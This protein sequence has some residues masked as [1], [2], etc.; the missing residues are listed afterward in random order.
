MKE[1]NQL[2]DFIAASP[3]PWHAVSAV[4]ALLKA[5]GYKPLQEND[6]W[7][8]V[9]GDRYY[10]VR[11]GS[12]LIA[13][14]MPKIPGAGWRMAAAHSDSPAF[15]VKGARLQNGCTLLDTEGYG[16]MIRASW[17]DR[18]LGLAG[19][20]LVRTETGVERRLIGPDRDL[21]VIPH[22]AIHFDRAMNEGHKYDLKKD[23]QALFA[24]GDKTERYRELLAAEASCR[25]EN[26]L[27]EELLLYC[28]Q[29]GAVAGAAGELI[30]CPRLDDLGC[31]WAT[32]KGFLA[33]EGKNP[34]QGAV[35]CLFDNEEVGSGTRQGACGSFLPD[36]LARAGA[37]LGENEETRRVALARSLLLSADNGHATHPNFAE[38]SDG[39]HPV[40]LNEGVVL[41]FNASQK[42][43]TSA[44]TAALFR[45]V[46]AA[47]GVPVQDYYNRADLPGGSTLG[48]LL[49][50]QVSVPMADVGL[51]QLAMHSCVETAGARDVEYLLTA[52]AA[53]YG[54]AIEPAEQGYRV[55]L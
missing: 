2:F 36:I 55:E 26:I 10:T 12:S 1:L 13:W 24:P 11:A 42:Y 43:T 35:W 37:A 52:C 39:G 30:L 28:R 8:L 6:C 48:N 27:S 4:G 21:A 34:T 40:R 47:A 31:A 19:R 38:M 15:K 16:G 54:A 18:P 23:M 7:S 20:V 22:L 14:R 5:A 3:T 53:W 33:A 32:L 51:P 29:P 9:P 49:S 25:P 41:K 46:C 50:A 44:E 17:M 45:A